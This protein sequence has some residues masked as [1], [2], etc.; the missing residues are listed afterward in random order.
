MTSP[1]FPIIF[2]D[3]AA[4]C[5]VS[6]VPTSNQTIPAAAV[7]PGMTLTG[8]PGGMLTVQMKPITT[9]DC[10]LVQDIN[11]AEDVILALPNVVEH[12][13]VVREDNDPMVYAG[14]IIQT[15]RYCNIISQTTRRG[16]GNV[17]LMGSDLWDKVTKAYAD[18]GTSALETFENPETLG[19]WE[20]KG[21]AFGTL[22][23]YVGDAIPANEVFV[24]YVGSGSA[25]DGPGGL[26]QDGDDLYLRVMGNTA[27]TLGNASD[28]T[29]RF[30]VVTK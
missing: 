7:S 16:Q 28:Y 12:D 5:R 4:E 1:L 14:V 23:V 24:A 17:V 9:A 20:K 22:P 29:R 30:R 25:I 19:R 8:S 15:M 13:I 3:K 10:Q 21:V 11:E 6:F 27:T 18:L 26:L 2:G